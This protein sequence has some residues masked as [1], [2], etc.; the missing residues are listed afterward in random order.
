[1]RPSPG[2][3]APPFQGVTTDGRRVSLDDFRGRKLVLYFYPRDDTP[4]CTRQACSLRDHMPLLA[5]KGAAVLGVSTQDVA[6]HRAFTSKHALNFPLLVDA[7]GEIGRAYGVLGG[8]GLLARLRTAAGLAE[9]VTFLID[10]D[11]LV[12]QVIDRPDVARH[13]E[14]VLA[15]L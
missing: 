6:S 9:R 13:G 5:A 3:P 2:D 8:P 15:L 10:R 4:G 12:V 14:E 1:M 11:G 7:D